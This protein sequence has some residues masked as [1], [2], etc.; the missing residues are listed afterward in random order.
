MNLNL[1]MEVEVSHVGVN[2][3]KLVFG[4]ACIHLLE[5]ET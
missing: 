4:T 1:E 3:F 2:F 5:G